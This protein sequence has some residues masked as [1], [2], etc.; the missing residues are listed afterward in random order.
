MSDVNVPN[1]TGSPATEEPIKDDSQRV[2]G[3]GDPIYTSLVYAFVPSGVGLGGDGGG[4]GMLGSHGPEPLFI[5]DTFPF[6][7]PE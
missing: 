4:K 5:V 1:S 3:P 6:V 7:P 2:K